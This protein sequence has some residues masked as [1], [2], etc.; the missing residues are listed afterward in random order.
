MLF[1]RQH[2]KLAFKDLKSRGS[3][4][5]KQEPEIQQ[6]CQNYAVYAFNVQFM[7]M[8]CLNWGFRH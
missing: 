2:Q 6:I 3:S 1:R 8:S 4:I 7:C 5:E